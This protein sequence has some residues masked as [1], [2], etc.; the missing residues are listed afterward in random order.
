MD[1][2]MTLEECERL[3]AEAV[4]SL[5]RAIMGVA[6]PRLRRWNTAALCRWDAPR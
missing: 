1:E 6:N 2:R 3:Y 4:A 5:K